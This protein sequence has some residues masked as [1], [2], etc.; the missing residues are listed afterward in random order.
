MAETTFLSDI[1]CIHLST[2]LVIF[3]LISQILEQFYNP[4]NRRWILTN[5]D[6]TY[7]L[8]FNQR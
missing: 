1:D 4:R 7:W 2:Q 8:I 5:G 3:K 6:W